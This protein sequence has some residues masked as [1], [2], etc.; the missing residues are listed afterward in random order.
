M[1]EADILLHVNASHPQY[2]DQIGAVNKTLQELNALTNQW[3]LFSI[4]WTCTKK[5]HFD[6]WLEEEVRAEILNELKERW[7]NEL[8]G[9]CVFI[10]AAEEETLMNYGKWSLTKCVICTGYAIHTKLITSVNLGFPGW[11]KNIT[12]IAWLYQCGELFAE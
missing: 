3:S 11:S 10:S 5:K 7:E 6:P 4:K 8:Q 9:N 2:E 12:G 1:R